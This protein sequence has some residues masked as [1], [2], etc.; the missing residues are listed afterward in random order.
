VIVLQK[1]LPVEKTAI[2]KDAQIMM[3]TAKKGILLSNKY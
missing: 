3:N 2:A 1:D